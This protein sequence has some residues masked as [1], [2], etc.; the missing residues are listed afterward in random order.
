MHKAML[1]DVSRKST[2]AVC[3][4]NVL[5]NVKKIQQAIISNN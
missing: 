3:L 1:V 5:Q 2:V 4:A